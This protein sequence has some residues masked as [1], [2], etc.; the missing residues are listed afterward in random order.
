MEV[1]N[2]C[3]NVCM[4][5]CMH[6]CMEFTVNI[7]TNKVLDSQLS[8]CALGQGPEKIH[9]NHHYHCH[10]ITLYPIHLKKAMSLSV[11]SRPLQPSSIL[12]SA[13]IRTQRYPSSKLRL[14][15]FC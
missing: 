11:K 15:K 7:T 10:P 13:R 14:Y 3:M 4:Y 2:L 1:Q 6:V 8:T 12:S 9:H 5:V